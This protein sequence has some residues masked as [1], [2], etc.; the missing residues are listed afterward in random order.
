MKV[1]SEFQV[2][3]QQENPNLIDDIDDDFDLSSLCFVAM[4][5]SV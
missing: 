1:T 2:A 5:L 4:L 3:R